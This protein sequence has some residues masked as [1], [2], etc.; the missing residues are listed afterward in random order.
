MTRLSNR[1]K[2]RPVVTGN[3][4]N[5]RPLKTP[6]LIPL[7]FVS[8]L[9]AGQSLVPNGSFEELGACDPYGTIQNATGWFSPNKTSPDLFNSCAEMNQ[10]YVGVPGNLFGYQP[11]QDGNGYVGIVAYSFSGGEVSYHEYIGTRLP[12]PLRE[13]ALYHVSFYVS[14][15]EASPV[16]VN[17]ISFGFS[18]D[19][20]GMYNDYVITPENHHDNP[21]VASD[22]VNWVEVSGYV[23]GSGTEIFLIIGNLR[24]DPDTDTVPTGMPMNTVY[25]Y[26][27]NVVMTEVFSEQPNVLTPNGDGINDRAFL[28]PSFGK[29]EVDMLD[30]WGNRVASVS[31]AEGWDGR[32]ESGEPVSEGVYFYAVHSSGKQEIL[33]SGFIQL[34]R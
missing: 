7:L 13:H 5:T 11:A 2:S 32:A 15:T 22:P 12:Q 14:M 8:C 10:L 6:F 3:S 25:Y 26:I 20:A 23:T 9:A 24:I 17:G 21:E 33:Q 28:A 19:T 27:D 30:R 16:A 34:I 1:S 29:M 4:K 31:F 18:Q